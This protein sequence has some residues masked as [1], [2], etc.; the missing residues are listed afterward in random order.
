MKFLKD[1]SVRKKASVLLGKV[2]SKNPDFFI[3]GATRS[4]T[5]FLHHLLGRHPDIFMPRTKE[6]HYFNH[7]GRYQENLK[8]YFDLFYGFQNETVYGEATPLYFETGTLY[9]VEGKITFFNPDSS[10]PRIHKH[11]P[12]AKIIVSLRDPIERIHSIYQKNLGQ[13]KVSVSLNQEIRSELEGGSRL[14]LIHRNRYDLHLQKVFELFSPSQVKIIIFENWTKNHQHITSE[15]CD[16]L[17]VEF[18]SLDFEEKDKNKR[19]HYTAKQ[20]TPFPDSYYELDDSL[21]EDIKHQL[22]PV[23]PYV[24]DLVQHRL[25]WKV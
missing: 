12:D 1:F 6:L 21:L 18:V 16:F 8:G 24:E 7:E 15:L 19:E 4:G 13:S 9:D 2:P 17:D 3:I 10:I 11:F 23:R 22:A 14:H 25:P 20:S 5:T